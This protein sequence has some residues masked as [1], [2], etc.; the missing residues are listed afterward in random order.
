LP[1]AHTQNAT[2]IRAAVRAANAFA[3]AGYEVFLDGIFGPWFMPLIRAQLA[4]PA[5][6]VVLRCDL[7][8]A[9]ER[10]A[11]RRAAPAD[12]TLVR[13][14]HTALEDM[15]PYEAHCLDVGELD[16]A[17]VELSRRRGLGHF[18]LGAFA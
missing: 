9:V 15:T 5:D 6:F 17:A 16:T 10:A 18:R 7:S 3:L 13:H 2:V 4:V 14:V 1:E 11:A 12:A 8:R